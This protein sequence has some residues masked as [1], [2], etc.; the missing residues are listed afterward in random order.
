MFA[1]ELIA[2]IVTGGIVAWIVWDAV[3]RYTSLPGNTSTWDRISHAF[4]DSATVIVMRIGTLITGAMA[5]ASSYGVL[6]QD[7]NVQQWLTSNLG[8]RWMQYLFLFFTI[9]GEVARR[10]TL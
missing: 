10:R 3:Q 9:A 6:F 1:L 5:T 7:T 4:S 8:P 2:A